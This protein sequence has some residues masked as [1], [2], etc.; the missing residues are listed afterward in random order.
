MPDLKEPQD[1]IVVNRAGGRM[2]S[3]TAA[4]ISVRDFPPIAS[5]EPPARGGGNRG[6]S[7]LEFILVALCA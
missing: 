2:L 6:P 1:Y 7:P 3:H 5:D 4:E